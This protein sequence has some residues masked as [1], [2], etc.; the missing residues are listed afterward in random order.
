[1][2]AESALLHRQVEEL[3]IENANLRRECESCRQGCGTTALRQSEE[4]FRLA[5][6]TS[7]DS[8]NLNRLSD[9]TYFDVNEGFTKLTGFTREDAIGKTSLELGI[10][11]D[12]EERSRLVKALTSAG[13]VE[14]FEARFRTKTGEVGI[15]LMSARVLRMGEEAVILSIT[16]DI[17]ERKK[18]DESLNRSE[19]QYRTIF[20]NAVEGFFQSTV[21]GAFPQGQPGSRNH[22][23]IQHPRGNDRGITDIG[24]AALRVPGGSRSLSAFLTDRE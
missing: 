21:G 12:P 1:M 18:L 6:H 8:I 20:E 11:C 13:Y 14:N 3:R 7:P 16:R 24:G 9:G 17:T 4:R 5:F 19:E 2:E 15:G 23:R 10:W 22:V